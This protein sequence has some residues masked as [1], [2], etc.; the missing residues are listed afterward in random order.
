MQV[1]VDF[2]DNATLHRFSVGNYLELTE[3]PMKEKYL[4]S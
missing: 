3:K 4:S 2:R 1:R